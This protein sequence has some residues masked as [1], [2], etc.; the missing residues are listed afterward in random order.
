L[1]VATLET[2]ALAEARQQ[3]RSSRALRDSAAACRCLA[4]LDEH[5]GNLD[6]ARPA[7]QQAW[8][9]CGN[10]PNLAIEIA[11]FHLRHRDYPSFDAF[12]AALPPSI[13]GH[14]RIAL[15]QAQ[16]ALER[17]DYA[18]VRR[19][20][21]REFATIREGELSL[22][23]LWFTAYVKEAEGLAGRE[24]TAAEKSRL[25]RDFP[26]PQQIDFRMK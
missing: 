18:T 16:V 21:Q 12:V 2:G 23:E 11:E 15:M 6:A 9:L 14:E 26:P 20:L 22:S 13:A 24:L 5:Q 7:Y 25:M 10:D 8:A 1:G 4:L 3:L 17:G 19:V